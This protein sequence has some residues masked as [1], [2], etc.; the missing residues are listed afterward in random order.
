M[1]RSPLWRR[2]VPRWNAILRYV[3]QQFPKSGW[4][5][6]LMIIFL[7]LIPAP[8]VVLATT[9]C[10]YPEKISGIVERVERDGSF[11]IA[12]F[13]HP[14]SLW[15]IEPRKSVAAMRQAI[16]DHT[17]GKK[18][19][20][21]WQYPDPY[22]TFLA[23][24]TLP[25]GTNLATTLKASN[26]AQDSWW[27]EASRCATQIWHDLSSWLDRAFSSLSRQTTPS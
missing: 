3:R 7:S 10:F 27:S 4:G 11:R 1:T 8:S 26:D 2:L 14:I 13:E 20:C 17:I 5:W 19:K 12:G 18:I 22:Q 25:D 23:A 21:T 24:C 16:E 6:A 15:G 9:T